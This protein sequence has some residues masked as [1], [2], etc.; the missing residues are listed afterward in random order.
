MHW[1]VTKVG[2]D[3]KTWNFRLLKVFFF[4]KG[5]AWTRKKII[6]TKFAVGRNSA[7]PGASYSRQGKWNACLICQEY[8]ENLTSW[9]GENGGRFATARKRVEWIDVRIL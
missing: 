3:T 2:Y 6:R 7:C 8:V 4:V 5:K 1:S 9:S